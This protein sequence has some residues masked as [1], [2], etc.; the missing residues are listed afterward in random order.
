VVG[1][2]GR[3]ELGLG[4]RQSTRPNLN[5]ALKRRDDDGAWWMWPA[6]PVKDITVA[7]PLPPSPQPAEASNTAAMPPPASSAPEKKKS[8]KKKVVKV[9]KV[10]AKEE[11]LANA[12]CGEEADGT[13]D[14]AD[15]NVDD[16]SAPTKA[17]KTGLGL[18]LDTD[19]VLKEWSGKGSMFAEGSMPESPESAAEVRVST[20]FTEFYL[21][22]YSLCQAN[23]IQKT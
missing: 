18:K 13:V 22:L 5:R 7:P 23:L 3:F 17:P 2:A 9:E 4:S 19:D 11:E 14:V 6:V 1:L 21:S 20:C 12:K 8:K 15:G 10:M 16:D